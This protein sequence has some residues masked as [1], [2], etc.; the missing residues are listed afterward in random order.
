[1]SGPPITI[2]PT[3]ARDLSDVGDQMQRNVKY[4]H[5]HGVVVITGAL[6]GD[7]PYTAIWCEQHEDVLAERADGLFDAMQIKTKKFEDGGWVWSDQQLRKS[8][9]RFVHLERQF[10][11]RINCFA[12]VSNVEL[13]KSKA[14]GQIKRSPP[15][16]IE[17]VIADS[18]L[19]NELKE[20]FDDLCKHCDCTAIELITVL[21]RFKFQLGPPREH[22]L[23]V[24][25]HSHVANCPQCRHMNSVSLDGCV[26][27]LVQ[28]V[29]RAS[30][31]E[32]RDGKKDYWAIIGRDGH[33]P[34]VAAKRV[35][36]EAMRE[37]L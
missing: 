31:L 12:F 15:L 18:I 5:A 17:A 16:L 23:E 37:V 30:S 4:Q 33:D 6:R 24:V 11:G 7:L 3:D 1:M 27:A 13:H 19:Q 35:T 26:D 21:K 32:V 34:Y 25:A 20:A 22:M 28:T 9:A 14:V 29:A 36:I 10:S 2:S 8:I